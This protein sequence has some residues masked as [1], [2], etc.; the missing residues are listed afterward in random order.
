MRIMAVARVWE[1]VSLRIGETGN[2]HGNR[3]YFIVATR[4]LPITEM[5]YNKF[6]PTSRAM[7]GLSPQNEL[8]YQALSTGKF[9][10]CKYLLF[11]LATDCTRATFTPL[12]AMCTVQVHL[13]TSITGLQEVVGSQFRWN[14][15]VIFSRFVGVCRWTK[16]QLFELINL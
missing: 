8:G 5:H 9:R 6:S 15:Q 14:S 3:A 2:L 4:P 12:A 7:V 10:E 16:C 11:D 1:C 13:C